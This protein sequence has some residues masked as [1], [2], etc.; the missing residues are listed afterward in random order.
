MTS[1]PTKTTPAQSN[2]NAV[3]SDV[4]AWYRFDKERNSFSF[5][6]VE[7]GHS[8]TESPTDHQGLKRWG[9]GQWEKRHGALVPGGILGARRLELQ[10]AP[11]ATSASSED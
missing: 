6:H 8:A 7:D 1:N 2:P 9:K 5:N 11:P 3:T 4:T 10:E